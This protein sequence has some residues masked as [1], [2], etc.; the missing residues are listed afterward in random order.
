MPTA[1]AGSR[2]LALATLVAAATAGLAGGCGRT[3]YIRP[4]P[5]FLDLEEPG[6]DYAQRMTTAEGVVISVRDLDNA[7][8]GSL[9][10]W[11]AA[12]KRRLRTVRGYA[13]LGEQEARAATGQAGKQL[14]FGHDESGGPYFYWIT[15]F[16]SGD[17][18]FV[19]EAGGKKE[20]FEAASAE[21]EQAIAAFRVP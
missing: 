21:I 19:V 6:S 20:A 17:R 8:E 1:A 2:A 13:L 14:R 18:V 3:E 12:I 7:Q 15:V 10:F 16:V 4:T 11:V 9:D 5:S